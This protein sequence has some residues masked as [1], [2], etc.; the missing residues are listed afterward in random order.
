[1]TKKADYLFG[2]VGNPINHSQSPFIHQSFARQTNISLSY[3]KILAPPDGFQQTVKNFFDN[4]GKGL[5]ITVPFKQEAFEL[6]RN[7]LSTQAEIAGAV[8][9]L[10]ISDGKLHGCN[11]DGAGLVTDLIR[12]GHTPA[13]KRIL[14]LGAGGAARGAAPNL[15]DT[16]CA[17]LYIANR[18][19]SKAQDLTDRLV[20]MLPKYKNRIGYGDLNSV[21]ITN[22][23]CVAGQWDI[24]INATSSSLVQ[25]STLNIQPNHAPK[26]IAYDMVYGSKP[27]SFM[28]QA[29]QQG[30]YKQSDGLGML[31]G[32]AAISYYIWLGIKP[33]ITP[34]LAMLRQ[35]L[36][37]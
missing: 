33:E 18:T 14:L 20:T 6:A 19:A 25:G 35:H 29:Q 12:L 22:P 23:N 26:A 34:V 27:T 17:Y 24:I 7:N 8:N 5:N 15:L 30:A 2:V 31:V 36:N 21:N 9:T 28:V 16:G 13:N 1:M 3:E 4:G 10:W 11:T 32:Q 37:N